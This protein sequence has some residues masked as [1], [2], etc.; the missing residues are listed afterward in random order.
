MQHDRNYRMPWT[1]LGS[2]SLM[3]FAIWVPMLCIPPME[4]ILKEELLLTH[5]QTSLLYAVPPLMLAAL[6][7]PGGFLADRIGVR[8]AAGIGIIII[9]VGAM[10]RGTATSASSLLTFTF[11]Y[12]VGVGLSMPN[13]PKLISGWVSPEKANI[14]T[15]I[16][17]SA[18]LTGE[19]LALAITMALI[20]PITNTFQGVF[21]IWGIPPIAAAVLWWILV[22]EPPRDD[23]PG[24]PISKGNIS[25]R[26]ILRNKNL[27]LV[28]I[29]FLLFSFFWNGWT[30][31]A[32]ALMMLKGATEDVA[33][34]I[35]SICLWVGI[36]AALFIPRLSHKIGLRKPFLWISAITL[37]L[38]AWGAIYISIP[39]SWPLMA[40]IGVALNTHI[41]I[42]FALPIEMVSK[43]DVGTASGMLLTAGGAGAFIGPLI[44]GRIFDLTGN[45]NLFLL[46][47]IGISIAATGIAFRI[48]E[49]GPRARISPF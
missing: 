39:L 24:E 23:A 8:K 25:F 34:L 40:L 14:A 49:T 48:P 18:M 4:H 46:V 32:P 19:A 2:A 47:L 16:Y 44:G 7:I 27:W 38:A 42:M 41:P 36:P 13:L 33:G 12:G 30:A 31:W 17:S 26:L 43:E 29:L 35:A 9:A 3:A 45:L 10:L 15:G 1:I 6:G 21:F 37:A 28:A 5:A 11:I 20:F 22:R